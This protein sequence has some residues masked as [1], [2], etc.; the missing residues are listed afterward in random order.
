MDGAN[1]MGEIYAYWL[2]NAD[3]SLGEPNENNS[4]Y[5][6]KTGGTGDD[7][8]K[9]HFAASKSRTASLIER[10]IASD[11][12]KM[13]WMVIESDIPFSQ[14]AAREKYHIARLKTHVSQGGC[15]ET[16]GG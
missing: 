15:N 13:A 8:A 2:K 1:S 3:G 4:L 6:G 14:L 16:W 7:R 12:H 5:V 9:E 11:G 10:K